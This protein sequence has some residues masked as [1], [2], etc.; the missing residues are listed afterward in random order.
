MSLV[1]I[2][3]HALSAAATDIA[4]IGATIVDARAAYVAA[5]TV[6][7]PAGADEVSMAIAGLF[8]DVGKEFHGLSGQAGAFHAAFAQALAASGS[9]Y[10]GAEARS[11]S[12]LQAAAQEVL[13]VVNPPVGG[14]LHGGGVDITGLFSSAERL[15]DNVVAGGLRGAVGGVTA[16]AALTGTTPSAL[17]SFSLPSLPS[18][19]LTG[20]GLLGQPIDFI[21]GNNPYGLFGTAAQ[22]IDT[23]AVPLGPFGQPL[24]SFADLLADLGGAGQIVTPT[25]GVTAFF[26]T[27]NIGATLIGLPQLS[28]SAGQ[29]ALGNALGQA[30]LFTAPLVAPA[31]PDVL[32]D[33][34][35]LNTLS[36][37][38]PSPIPPFYQV[39]PIIPQL[40]SPTIYGLIDVL[41][42]PGVTAM[43][44]TLGSA[45]TVR[46]LNTIADPAI[47]AALLNAQ[48]SPGIA[49]MFASFGPA[50]TANM[51]TGLTPALTNTMINDLGVVGEVQTLVDFGP[52]NDI[53]LLQDL[54]PAGISLVLQDSLGISVS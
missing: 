11:V 24:L 44:V 8:S 40:T 4:D 43:D 5:T 35:S 15:Y 37:T 28:A 46:L 7:S 49:N 17:G 47:A 18:I 14:Q 48:G 26:S 6:L 23:V 27:W 10:A 34:F 25:G 33:L 9:A 12:L 16:A 19:H 2:I 20:G 54:G 31:T 52:L 29:T 51:V 1:S 42:S 45:N 3:P 32:I 53:A 38:I 22:L 36:I 39:I 21:L 13:G 50:G 30:G 41:G